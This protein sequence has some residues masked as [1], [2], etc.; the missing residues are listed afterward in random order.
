MKKFNIDPFAPVRVI[1]TWADGE[2]DDT[3]FAAV[4]AAQE[5]LERLTDPDIRR[6][7]TSFVRLLEETLTERRFG[8]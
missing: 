3:L 2:D 1:Q 8:A 7:L 4:K 6:R 5:L